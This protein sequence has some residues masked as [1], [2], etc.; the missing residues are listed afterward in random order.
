MLWF[1]IIVKINYRLIVSRIGF[2]CISYGWKFQKH[3][4]GSS[5]ISLWL[6][7]SYCNANRWLF[8]R[9]SPRFRIKSCLL[10]RVDITWFPMS[11]LS[12][13]SCCISLFFYPPSTSFY[14]SSTALLHLYPSFSSFFFS[15]LPYIQPSHFL[16][17]SP[18]FKYFHF[19]S[20]LPP[21]SCAFSLFL[22]HFLKVMLPVS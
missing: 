20:S 3:L 10:L 6:K 19:N 2:L 16:I 9:W 5:G 1:S 13:L 14:L 12:H 18:F 21:L 4:T 8:S 11:S 7:I 22:F 15:F 17:S